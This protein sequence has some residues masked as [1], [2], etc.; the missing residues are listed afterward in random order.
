MT[1]QELHTILT[2]ITGF[3]DKVA[4]RAF[5]V[6]AAPPLP[7]IAYIET[8]ANNF[9]ADGV[10]Y[11]AAHQVQVELYTAERDLNSEALVEKALTD[12]NIYYTKDIAY[13]DDELCYMIIYG[14]EI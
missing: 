7:F 4:Y 12:N 10:V 13:L 1:L 11:A 5:P 2:G 3:A 6:D 14:T 8:G 9:A